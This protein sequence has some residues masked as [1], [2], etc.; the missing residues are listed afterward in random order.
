[1]R[2]D[3]LFTDL[4]TIVGP[5]GLLTNAA[6]TAAYSLEQRGNFP[7]RALAVVRPRTT[8]EVSAVVTACASTNTSIIPQG[9]NT[10][11]VGGSTPDDSGREI[12]LSLERMRE[13]R[14]VSPLDNTITVESGCVLQSVQ[15]AALAHGRMFPL[16]LGSEGS[17][18]I[19]GNISTNAGGDQVI[20]YGNTRDQVL[21]LEVVLADGRILSGL[22]PLRKD[23]SGYDLKHLF[24]GGEGTLGVVTAA[25]LKLYPLLRQQ[26]TAWIA[27]QDARHAVAL[28]AR[29]RESLGDR[30]TAFEI[31]ARAT[32]DLVIKHFPDLQEPLSGSSPWILLVD[33]SDTSIRYPL[34]EEFQLALADGMQQGLILDAAMA[35]SERQSRTMWEIRTNI[36]EAQ[37]REGPSLKHDISVPISRIADFID[38]TV[39]KMRAIVPGIQCIT[40]GHVGDGNL[41]FNQSKPPDMDKESF[42]AWANDIHD[43]VHET[44]A[45]MQ[46]SI[47]AEHGIGRQ[48]QDIFIRYKD[49]AAVSVMQQIKAAL[50]PGNLFNPGRLLPLRNFQ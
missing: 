38:V 9:G 41:H 15:E 1:M 12:V 35:S 5:G 42:L 11:L 39:P 45:H 7:G 20:R 46:G 50:D 14:Q 2:P 31:M 34:Q 19:G 29:L 27:V 28:L 32:V 23:N 4:E 40:F 33:V 21:G 30:V 22:S 24:I 36:S 6:D 16:T 43:L 10:G 26:A 44:A 47:S 25:T 3:T 17:A 8:A 48:K 49:P 13:I 37:R 18:T